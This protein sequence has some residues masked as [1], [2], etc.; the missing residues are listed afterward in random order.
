MAT[1]VPHPETGEQT[2]AL[3]LREDG[4]MSRY[5]RHVLTLPLSFHGRT[6]SGRL[7]KAMLSGT[8]GLFSS[9]LV[10]FRDQLSTIAASVSSIFVLYGIS[11]CHRR[12]WAAQ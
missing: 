8:D 10:F 5:F 1:P 4:S 6:H 12:R 3:R 7:N 2:E 9:W 11:L